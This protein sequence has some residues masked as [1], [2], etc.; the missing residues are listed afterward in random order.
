MGDGEPAERPCEVEV[1]SRRL[2]FPLRYGQVALRGARRGPRRPTSSTPRRRTPPPRPQRRPR[3]ARSSRSSS[4][5]PP[6]SARSATA[7]STARSRS[8][9]A[10][11]SR[12]GT[13]PQGRCGRAPSARRRRSSSRAPTSPRSRGGGGSRTRGVH[14]L[15]NPA[16][17]PTRGRARAAR[18]GDV[19]LRRP[20]HA[21]EGSRRRDRGCRPRAGREARR[22]RRRARSEPSSSAL[23]AASDG[24]SGCASSA[25][26]TRDETLRIVAGA[27]A[28]LLSSDWENLPHSAVEALSVGVPVVSTAVGGVPEVVTDGENG[29]L[30]PPGDPES[31]AAAIRRILEEPGLRDRLAAAAKPSVEALSSDVVYGKLEALLVGG[32]AMTERPARSLR[33]TR[34]LP[35]AAAGVAREEVGRGRARSSTTA[36]SGRRPADSGPSD[37]RFRLA[38]RPRGRAGSTGSSSTSGCRCGCGARSGASGREA[39]F[40]SDP[41]RR[42]GSARRPGTGPPAG[43]GDRRGA[44]RLADVLAPL[45]LACAPADRPARRRRRGA[46]RSGGP[47]RRV[48]SRASPRISSRRSRGVPPSAVF[49]AFSDL[50][51]FAERPPAPLPERPTVRVRRRARGVQERRGARRRVAA[52]SPSECLRPALVIVGSG[53]QQAVVDAARGGLSRPGRART[54]GSSP[55]PSP[56]SSTL[57]RCS[58]CPPGRR[59]SAA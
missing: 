12:A 10:R 26:R 1:V 36:S 37:D 58:C 57:R 3:G 25:L 53:S 47:T 28:G 51:A 59:V 39:I 54:S 16:P 30:V 50:S 14:V 44:R 34:A 46:A 17:P 13:R 18:A 24:A 15:T 22:R 49:T 40:A 4:P 27:E 6:T 42:R 31:L 55:R 43:A 8:S 35:P 33:R 29:L 38:R 11:A 5:T 21:A 32:C 19:R 2:P 56:S 7:C 9:R 48:P 45:R 52:A 23:A 41:V 20:A